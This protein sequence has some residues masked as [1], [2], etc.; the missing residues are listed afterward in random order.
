MAV[1]ITNMDMPK[2]CI[3]CSI[4]PKGCA[5]KI[6]LH[7]RAKDCPLKSA[8]KMIKEIKT[9]LSWYLYDENGNETALC[10][11]LIPIIK[12]YCN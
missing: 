1:I 5:S 3:E 8:D 7:R 12:K 9:D 6:N 4:R 11:E 2:S 10:K